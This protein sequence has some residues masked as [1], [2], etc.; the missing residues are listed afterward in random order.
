MR[1]E[2]ALQRIDH[3]VSTSAPGFGEQQPSLTL[4]KRL[5]DSRSFRLASEGGDFAGEPLRLRIL[6]VERHGVSIIKW[7][8]SAGSALYTLTVVTS[9][10][11]EISVAAAM[12]RACR[13]HRDRLIVRRFMCGVKVNAGD[14]CSCNE[15]M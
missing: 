4:S 11:T 1:P 3:A 5:S 2:V 8:K 13:N 12:V 10:S 14:R 15:P 6:D 9:V 7:C